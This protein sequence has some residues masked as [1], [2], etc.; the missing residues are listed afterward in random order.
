MS[1]RDI[2]EVS[3]HLEESVARHSKGLSNQELY[4]LY[5]MTAISILDSE[6]ANYPENTLQAYLEKLLKVKRVQLDIE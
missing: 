5:E 2:S 1:I 4:D 6:F 3:A